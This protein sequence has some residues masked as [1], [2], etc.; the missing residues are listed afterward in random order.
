MSA[1]APSDVQSA[2][3][4]IARFAHRFRTRT[5]PPAQRAVPFRALLDT[6]AVAV[7]AHEDET[8]RLARAYAAEFEGVG[9]GSAWVGA[10]RLPA[11]T[12]A[13]LNAIAAHVL[14]YDDVLTPM[15]AHVSATLVP[16]LLAL[17]PSPHDAA[18][19]APGFANAYIAGF[20]VMAKFARA[21][22]LNHYS[23]G[24]HS[25]SALGVLGVTVACCV[26]LDLD[27]GQTA[28]ALGLAVAQASG[29]RENFGAMAKSFQAGVCA[30]AAVRAALLAQRGFTAARSA[31]DGSNGY[32]RLYAD[33]EDLREVL[34]QLGGSPLEIEA[35]GIDQKK[36]PCCY[37][38]HRALDAVLALRAEHGFT[39][40]DVAAI[41]VVTSARGREALIAGMP[42]DA[43]QAK[44]S[45]E[46]ALASAIVDGGVSMRT[47]TAAAFERAGVHE[48]MCKVTLEEA[49]GAVLPRWSAVTLQCT[50]G[51]RL[52]RRV[53]VAHGDAGDPLSDDELC[54]KA[55]DCFAHA[56]RS[57]WARRVSDAV[58]DARLDDR[59]RVAVC[60]Q[61]MP[62]E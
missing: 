22:A 21:M 28:N 38:V 13:W 51:R 34:A 52:E 42:A 26:L 9:R 54:A 48:L 17:L 47:F 57:A 39:P 24:W 49:G 32:M 12:A 16:A 33:R 45:M 19:A 41:H 4:T 7:A 15:R 59:A 58:L 3:D 2:S 55:H 61:A 43:L 23:K 46:Y 53:R 18:P 29:T 25:T 62:S 27:Q 31:I 30:A 6:F 50:D 5:L 36:Y 35:M 8:V 10:E 56:G 37:A 1:A 14:D 40:N 11:E 44:F 60:L 20:E